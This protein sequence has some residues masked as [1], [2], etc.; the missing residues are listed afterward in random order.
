MSQNKKKREMA[1]AEEMKRLGSLV[2]LAER[3][4]PRVKKH[5]AEEKEKRNAGKNAKAAA[6]AAA[7][8]QGGGQG[9]QGGRGE[10]QS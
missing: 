7:D 3:F 6:K 5:Q 4:D 10:G 2:E 9:S 8:A 1:K